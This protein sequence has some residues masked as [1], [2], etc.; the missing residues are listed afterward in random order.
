MNKTLALLAAALGV[1]FAAPSFAAEPAK[2]EEK[3]AIAAE[4][5]AKEEKTPA[6][7]E[8]KEEEKLEG[9]KANALTPAEG[10]KEEKKH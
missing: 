6:T 10:K 4:K 8:K 9:E 2:K 3:P 7:A 1:A 5:A